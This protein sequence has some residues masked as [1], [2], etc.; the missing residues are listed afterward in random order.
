MAQPPDK[1]GTEWSDAA[2]LV[3]AIIEALNRFDW[4]DV[5]RL[6][7]SDDPDHLGLLQRQESAAEPFPAEE[8]KDLLRHLRRKRRFELMGVLA[9]AFLRAG[10]TDPEIQRQYSQAMIDLA[11]LSAAEN[12]LHRILSD[13]RSPQR[14]QYEA[15]GLLG[16]IYKQ[17]YVNAHQPESPR[18]QRNLG[19]AVDYYWQAYSANRERNIW[20][21]V[22]VAALL[23]GPGGIR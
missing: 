6:C 14:E 18:Q 19:Q 23:A 11:N 2:K 17:L 9:D 5:E 13:P 4:P 8:S 15:N 16:R 12:T 22:N 10:A 20:Q 1:N 7:R 3:D 21:G